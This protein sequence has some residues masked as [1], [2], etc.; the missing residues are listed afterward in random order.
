MWTTEYILGKA[1]HPSGAMYQFVYV[2]CKHYVNIFISIRNYI[3]YNT[4]V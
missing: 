3:V 2:V 1:H 4:S